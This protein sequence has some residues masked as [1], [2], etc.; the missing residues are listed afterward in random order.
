MNAVIRFRVYLRTFTVNAI[1]PILPASDPQQILATAVG[2][3]IEHMTKDELQ[4]LLAKAQVDLQNENAALQQRI[5]QLEEEKAQLEAQYLRL[6]YKYSRSLFHEKDWEN[7]DPSEYSGSAEEL[8]AMVHKT[9]AHSMSGN[10][11]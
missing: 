11:A 8:L 3:R 10:V 5:K 4:T 7:F 9:P 1:S 2:H 6:G